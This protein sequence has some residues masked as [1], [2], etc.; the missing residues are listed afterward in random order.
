MV[1]RPSVN[2]TLIVNI[3][4]QL[5]ADIEAYVFLQSAILFLNSKGISLTTTSNIKYPTVCYLPLCTIAAY[6]LIWSWIAKYMLR[7][8]RPYVNQIV[9]REKLYGTKK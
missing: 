5:A 7:T 3:I 9:E 6:D 4:L 2:V 1:S 8:L